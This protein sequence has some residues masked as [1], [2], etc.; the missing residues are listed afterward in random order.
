[1]KYIGFFDSESNEYENRISH[2]SSSNKMKYVSNTLNEIGEKVEII[3][4]SWTLNNSYYKGKKVNLTNDIELIL[5]PTVPYVRYISQLLSLLFLTIYLIINCKK[6]ET[7]IVYHSLVLMPVINILKYIK[8]VK[9]IL[10]VEE[11][12]SLVIDEKNKKY[13]TEMKYIRS[14]DKRIVVSTQL[15]DMIG[16]KDDILLYGSYINRVDV[17]IE[18]NPYSIVYA[19]TIDK[20]KGG[21]FTA[22]QMMEYIESEKIKLYVLGTG[23]DKHLSEI[24]HMINKINNDKGYKSIIFLGKKTGDEFNSLMNKFTYALNLQNTGGYMSSAFPSK[25]LTYFSFGQQVISTKIDS[26]YDSNFSNYIHFKN[27]D[28]LELLAKE[29]ERMINNGTQ[30]DNV[31]TLILKLHE[32]FKK[33]LLDIIVKI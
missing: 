20:L 29:I 17:N 10:E 15:K 18:K 33:E 8:K 21:S 22:V 19:G 32:K 11:V 23:G 14:M 26:I 3:S 5:F 13:D 4:P 27:N 12:Y 1:M 16:Y 7:L 31:S 24:E 6:S 9:I 25:I 2:M 30:H 28:N